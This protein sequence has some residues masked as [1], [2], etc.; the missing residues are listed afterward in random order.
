V[1]GE[2]TASDLVERE[3][4]SMPAS[5]PPLAPVS[6]MPRGVLAVP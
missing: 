3:D 4:V 2:R 6:S 1:G 5:L